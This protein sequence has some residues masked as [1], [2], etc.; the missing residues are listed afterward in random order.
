MCY[1]NFNYDLFYKMLMN[2]CNIL[3]LMYQ[4]KIYIADVISEVYDG[5]TNAW[6][7][8]PRPING[9]NFDAW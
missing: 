2:V 1:K 7:F 8:W 3:G 9:M 4:N 5:A 6:T